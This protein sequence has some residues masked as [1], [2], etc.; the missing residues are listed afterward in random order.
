VYRGEALQYVCSQQA[1]SLVLLLIKSYQCFLFLLVDEIIDLARA[2]VDT[3][4]THTSAVGVSGRKMWFR[5]WGLLPCG[6]V[7]LRRR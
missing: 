5:P 1:R 7:V 6:R 3:M 4:R 2:V